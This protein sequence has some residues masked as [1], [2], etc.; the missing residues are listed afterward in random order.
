MEGFQQERE[1]SNS[2]KGSRVVEEYEDG[3]KAFG[4][5][6]VE[7]I[8]YLGDVS[9]GGMYGPEA[10]LQGSKEELVERKSRR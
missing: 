1:S 2:V 8:S 3:I 6:T 4:F 9:F 5:S 10:R 7:V